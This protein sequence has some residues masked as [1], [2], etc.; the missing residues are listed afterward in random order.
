MGGFSGVEFS[1]GLLS[2]SLALIAESGH[3]LADGLALGIAILAHRL[4]QIAASAQAPFGYRRVE[5][6]AALA[7][8]VGLLAVAGWVGWEAIAQLHEP[9]ADILSTPMLITAVVG[10]G[11]NSINALLLHRHSHHDLN[12]RGAFLHIVSDILGSMGVIVAAIAVGALGWVWADRLVS[13]GVAVIIAASALPL[14]RQSLH[15]LLEK[16]PRHLDLHAIQVHLDSFES[17]LTAANVRVWAIAPGQEILSA[18][19]TVATLDGHERDCLLRQ[20]TESLQQKFGIQDICLQM[21][22]MLP[23]NTINLSERNL[24][25]LEA[26]KS[27]PADV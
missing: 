18:H 20:I 21:S 15:I 26:L 25:N 5:I 10:L 12:V 23:L 8:G 4:T 19:L 6:L 27:M 9:H 24:F 13:I 17:V 11:I 7:N 2:H 22:G 14:I 1:V 16:S 3:M